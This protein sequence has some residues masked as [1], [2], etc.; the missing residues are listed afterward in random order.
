[1]P[2]DGRRVGDV[3]DGGR[4]DSHAATDREDNAFAGPIGGRGT[5]PVV[6]RHA[7][8]MRR[9]ALVIGVLVSACVSEGTEAAE[10][11]AP[12]EAPASEPEPES[13]PA[14][15]AGTDE[16]A[17]AGEVALDDAHARG[18]TGLR[19][20]APQTAGEDAVFYAALRSQ[21]ST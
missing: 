12:S 19:P 8:A 9:V 16:P 2:S 17:A 3:Q 14:P 7:E 20:A 6:V 1:M 11:V 13:R 5:L 21:E 18:D 4:V 10:A 15:P